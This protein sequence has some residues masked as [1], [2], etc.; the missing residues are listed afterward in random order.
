MIR[1]RVI[2]AK[3]HMCQAKRETFLIK[4]YKFMSFPRKRETSNI[5][6][7]YKRWIPAFAGMTIVGGFLVIREHAKVILF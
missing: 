7:T 5:N 1:S 3:A 4:T 2:P 6:L